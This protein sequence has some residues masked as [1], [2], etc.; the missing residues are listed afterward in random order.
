MKEER[1]TTRKVARRACRGD[2][3]R[4]L[5]EDERQFCQRHHTKENQDNPD[6]VTDVARSIGVLAIASH[7]GSQAQQSGGRKVDLWT[8]SARWEGVKMI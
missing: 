2:H 3:K 5:V 8:D 4:V 7:V 1:G 6:H